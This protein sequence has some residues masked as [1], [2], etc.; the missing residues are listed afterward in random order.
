MAATN[1]TVT[2]GSPEAMRAF[3]HK[4]AGPD[5]FMLADG[6]RVY[7]VTI[8]ANVRH[9]YEAAKPLGGLV[10]ERDRSFPITETMNVIFTEED[11]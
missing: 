9:I 5:A 6:K 2:F 7:V 4:A 8:D 3:I 11:E 1:L 10:V